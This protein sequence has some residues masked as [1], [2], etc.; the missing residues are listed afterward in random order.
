ME[1]R[2][3]VSREYKIMLR[4]KLFSGA[5]QS[6]LG[7]AHAL[8]RDVAGKIGPVALGAA[9]DLSRIKTRRLISF[10][11]T[12]THRLNEAHYI[13]RERRADSGSN[14]E[15]TLK[16]RHP[17]RFLA[18]ARDMQAKGRLDSKTKFEEDI[19][20]PF[21]SLHSF[22][23]TVAIG[24]DATF[25]KLSDVMRLFPGLANKLDDPDDDEPLR[26]VNNFTAREVVVDGATMQIGIT[27][28]V[29]A[30]WAL[31]VWY[32]KRGK[33]DKPVA[34]E[35]SYRYGDK[36][37]EYGGGVTRRASDVFDAVRSKLKRWVD[38]KPITKT[39][40]IF[41]RSSSTDGL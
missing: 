4:P 26:P 31:I 2:K 37:E 28:K 11:D 24:D 30:E 14:R 12:R 15:L 1:R 22:S 35:L 40:F 25:T 19:K 6:L 9:G 29:D 21:V 38:P 36:D 7:H 5:E 3:V 41:K 18:Q 32:D 8:W 20:A 16:Y 23:T 27:P 10:F 33:A 34:V 39:A 17:D 13:L